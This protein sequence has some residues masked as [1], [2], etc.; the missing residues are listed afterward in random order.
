M[1][2]WTAEQV[3]T[4][5]RS[6][7]DQRLYAMWRLY[8]TTGMRRGE[9]LALR[10]ADLALDDGFLMV[11]QSR[12]HG[13]HGWVVNDP[14]TRAGQRRVPLDPATVAALKAHLEAQEVVGP[15]DYAFDRGDGTPLDPDGVSGT[16]DRLSRAAKLPRIRLHDLRHTAATL[17]LA[18]G[19][20]PKV[21]QE[22]LGHSSITMT[23]D[24]YSHVVP[25]LQDEA[26][27]RLALL[28]DGPAEASK[29]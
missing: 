24:L 25:T 5:L 7:E 29:P 26:A 17:M 1:K 8:A 13:V 9:V 14:K 2:T 18:A 19:T 15:D 23:L 16:F 21:V 28:I 11:R 27:D 20:N 10:R 3:R 4:F 6:V 22:R 12:V